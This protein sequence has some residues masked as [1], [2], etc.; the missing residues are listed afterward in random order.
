LR[1]NWQDIQTP[2][3]KDNFNPSVFFFVHPK[4][5]LNHYFNVHKYRTVTDESG[6]AV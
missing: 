5:D 2:D 1:L 4:S 3:K 6:F